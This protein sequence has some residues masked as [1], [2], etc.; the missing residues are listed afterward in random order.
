MNYSNS[1]LI[2]KTQISPKSNPRTGPI[3]KITIHHAAGCMGMEALLNYVATVGRDMSANYVLSGGKL[4]LCVEEKN[5][6]W[7]SSNRANDMAAVT[8][9]V[10]NSSTGGTWPISD[11]DL[12]M[13]ITWCA[14]VCKRNG[15][16]KLY[17]DGTPNGSLTLHEMFA[18][19]GCP[20]PYIKSKI[21]YIC[22]SVNA[23]LNATA[24]KPAVTALTTSAAGHQYE[25]VTTLYGYVC[26]ADAVADRNRKRTIQAGAY[27]VYNATADAIN[28]TKNPNVPGAWISKK[29]N[30]ASTPVATKKPLEEIACA[31]IRGEWGNGDARKTKLQAA[32]Y[33]PAA[34][35]KLVNNIV[36]GNNTPV[37][38][39]KSVAQIAQEVIQGKWGNG[40]DRKNRLAA[41][42]YD[43]SAV[44]AAVNK[45]V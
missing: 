28:V 15:I 6:A 31:V 40:A 1:P 11:A 33:D 10:S 13:L 20:G 44:Q 30:V 16:P 26:A 29:A 39:A 38:P 2:S 8:I 24:E 7:T 18:S 5:R 35:Q 9:E 14:D 17:Y 41:A 4:G 21:Q 25:V 27:Y 22:D 36:A 34:V 43:P 37:A 45:L 12:K 32:G 23:L 3:T 19:T 42:G